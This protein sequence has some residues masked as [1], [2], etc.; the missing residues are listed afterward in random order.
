[1]IRFKAAFD[2]GFEFD[3]SVRDLNEDKVL[4]RFKARLRKHIRENGYE[5]GLFWGRLYRQYHDRSYGPAIAAANGT[6]EGWC[7]FR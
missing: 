6:G 5:G 1:M 7:N 3:F 4:K 2:D